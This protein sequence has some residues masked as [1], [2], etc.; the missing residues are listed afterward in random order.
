M[1]MLHE[2]WGQIHVRPTGNRRIHIR[3]KES[4]ILHIPVLLF[5]IWQAEFHV[6]PERQ[7]GPDGTVRVC[8]TV[9]ESFQLE[10][11]SIWSSAFPIHQ[12]SIHKAGERISTIVSE[13]IYKYF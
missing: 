1:R 3:K 10:V 6:Q 4:K 11:A 13:P 8:L 7:S 2:R 5:H 9:L 12:I